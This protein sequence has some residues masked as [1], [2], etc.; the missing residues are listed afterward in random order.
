MF[1]YTLIGA[2]LYFF[3]KVLGY[4]GRKLINLEVM[5]F[6]PGGQEAQIKNKKKGR[7]GKGEYQGI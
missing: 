4:L 2:A 1:S 5:N 6:V 7:T 3:K